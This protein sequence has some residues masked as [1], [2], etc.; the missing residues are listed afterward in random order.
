MDDL[1]KFGPGRPGGGG[2]IEGATENEA[3][4]AG[5]E[6]EAGYVSPIEGITDSE[7]APSYQDEIEAERTGSSAGEETGV[8]GDT[9]DD[10]LTDA[11]DEE[12]NPN[13]TERQ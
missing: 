6:G 8:S 5:D 11:L 10:V 9:R 12:R 13:P 1:E 3:D 4:P 2:L 7:G